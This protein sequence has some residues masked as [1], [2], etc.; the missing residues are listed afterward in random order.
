MPLANQILAMLKT[1]I[2]R[3]GIQVSRKAGRFLARAGKA[4]CVHVRNVGV[5]GVGGPEMWFLMGIS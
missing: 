4:K 5:L 1:V 3:E 2:A